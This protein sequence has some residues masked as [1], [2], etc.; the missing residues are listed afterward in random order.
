MKKIT[1]TLVLAASALAA[2]VLQAPGQRTVDML[3]VEARTRQVRACVVLLR[4]MTGSPA[5]DTWRNRIAAWTCK[6]GQFS[7]DVKVALGE[8]RG[9][10]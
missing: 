8:E 5:Q 1:I 9:R 2:S 4:K 10:R 7:P 3:G 6:N